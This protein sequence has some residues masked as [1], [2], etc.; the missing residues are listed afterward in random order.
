MSSASASWGR[1]GWA[2]SATSPARA[3]PPTPAHRL[4]IRPRFAHTAVTL[5]IGSGDE[6][7]LPTTST[8][9]ITKAPAS[10]R[11]WV[12]TGPATGSASRDKRRREP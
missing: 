1:S 12:S 11:V 8:S 7:K 2:S 9:S 5:C 10:W 6:V 4:A 3:R